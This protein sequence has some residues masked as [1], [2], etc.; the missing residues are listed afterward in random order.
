M[1]NAHF[2][3]S[4]YPRSWPGLVTFSCVHRLHRLLAYS[5]RL[6][7]VASPR[8]GAQNSWPQTWSLYSGL[9][10]M[11]I[12]H[13]PS[14]EADIGPVCS[15][16]T[17]AQFALHVPKWM[18]KHHLGAGPPQSAHNSMVQVPHP[19]FGQFA[20]P[21]PRTSCSRCAAHASF[22]LDNIVVLFRVR[23][24][25]DII[26]FAR[27]LLKA[28]PQARILQA[29]FGNL[30]HVGRVK[31]GSCGGVPTFMFGASRCQ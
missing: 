26:T 19:L 27:R 25:D 21:T 4:H 8:H 14:P 10:S 7:S 11:Q 28:V 13:S 17:I 12:G 18:L 1:R 29:L 31:R 5:W 6:L 30:G 22:V 20:C 9:V 3:P 15:S 2:V 24:W 23:G 16:A